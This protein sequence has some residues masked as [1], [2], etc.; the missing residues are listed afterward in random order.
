M[1]KPTLY[2]ILIWTH[3]QAKGQILQV[4]TITHKLINILL[5][6]LLRNMSWKRNWNAIRFPINCIICYLVKKKRE[7]LYKIGSKSRHFLD[8]L[9]ENWKIIF[10]QIHSI[11]S[12]SSS[13]SRGI[14]DTCN[15]DAFCENTTNH[16]NASS[17]PT[18]V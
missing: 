9:E 8:N 11:A 5:S 13:T 4:I 6:F 10:I 15:Q 1:Y 7:I 17:Q 12:M 14:I 3:S 2:V 18:L 16:K